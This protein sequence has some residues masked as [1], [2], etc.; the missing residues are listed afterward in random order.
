M[1]AARVAQIAMPIANGIA[2]KKAVE[3]GAL[4]P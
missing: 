2:S 3:G 1:A 4:A